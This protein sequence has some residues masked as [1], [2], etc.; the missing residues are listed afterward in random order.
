MA[1]D[2]K[3]IEI[4]MQYAIDT[5]KYKEKYIYIYIYPILQSDLMGLING[6]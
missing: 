4:C 2:Y 5:M 6:C 3:S 1:E